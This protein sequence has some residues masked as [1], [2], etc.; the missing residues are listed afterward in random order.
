VAETERGPCG[1]TFAEMKGVDDAEAREILLGQPK[2]YLL[3]GT[4][5]PWS[6]QKAAV[7]R[8]RSLGLGPEREA[9]VLWEN[10]RRLLE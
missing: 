6:S 4:D 3:F 10:A 2:E 8:V 5:S 1:D 7:A 9:A